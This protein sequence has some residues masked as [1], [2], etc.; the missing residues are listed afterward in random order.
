MNML[1]AL[2]FLLILGCLFKFASE[3]LKICL[4]LTVH[5]EGKWI[6]GFE[7]RMIRSYMDFFF[8]KILLVSFSV[9]MVLGLGNPLT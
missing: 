9:A 6:E 5:E 8:I 4:E 2:S 1:S 3:L 7:Y